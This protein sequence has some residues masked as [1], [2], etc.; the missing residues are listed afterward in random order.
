MNGTLDENS[1]SSIIS[2][3]GKDDSENIKEE[4]SLKRNAQRTAKGKTVKYG[5]DED[6]DDENQEN[7]NDNESD[8]MG[9]D[10][11]TEKKVKKTKPKAN[12][13]VN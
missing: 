4:N 8:Y 10:S 12:A 11:E 6:N 7:I 5:S 2:I 9:S 13:P 3:D 1:N